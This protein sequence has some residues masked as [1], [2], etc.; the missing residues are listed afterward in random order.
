[1]AN[2][3]SV[4]QCG[5]DDSRIGRVVR[6]ATGAFLDRA[7]SA[8]EATRML[9]EKKYDLVLVNRVFDAG[10]EGLKFIESLKQ[11]SNATPVMLV[12]DYADAQATAIAN[13]AL[14][15]FGKSGLSAPEVGMRIREAVEGANH[16]AAKKPT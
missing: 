10:G 3:L 16:E 15:G 1:M 11:S 14:M 4:G 12:S 7:G 8:E 13:G 5:Y 9:A 6:E 2:V